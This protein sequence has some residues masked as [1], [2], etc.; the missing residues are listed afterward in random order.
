MELMALVQDPANAELLQALIEEAIKN[1]VAD[2]DISK[3]RAEEIF[4]KA[5]QPVTGTV[6]AP[7]KK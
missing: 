4:Q 2:K 3:L 5:I 6:I 1:G 7:V